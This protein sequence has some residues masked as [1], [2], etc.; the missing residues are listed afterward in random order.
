MLEF[1]FFARFKPTGAELPK[2]GNKAV[3]ARTT[4]EILRK[5]IVSKKS[6]VQKES[7]S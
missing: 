4:V 1:E 6:F 3:A 7:V 2:E 5:A